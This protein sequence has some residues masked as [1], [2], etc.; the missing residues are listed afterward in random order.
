MSE[1]IVCRIALGFIPGIGSSLTRQLISYCNTAADV[2][3]Q[4]KARLLKI[5]GIGN[6]LADAIVSARSKAMTDAEKEWQL[7]EK[8]KVSL[9]FYTDAAYPDRLKTIADAPALLYYA[10]NANLNEKKVVSIVG[11]RRA[12]EYGKKVTE[13]LVQD[14]KKH[15]CLIVSGLAYGIDIA[16]HRAALRYGLPTIGVMASGVDI[17]YPS[18]HRAT[19]A[20]MRESGGL[21]TENRIGSAPDAPRFPA[22]NRIIAGMADATIVVEAADKGGALITAEL[23]NSYDKD[24]FAVPGNVNQKSSEGCNKLIAKHKASLITSA[25]DIEYFMN[26]TDETQA[27]H[28]GKAKIKPDFTLEYSTEEAIILSLLYDQPEMHID[29]ISWKAQIPINKLSSI[30]LE[31]EFR[32]ILKNL[33][34]KKFIL[35]F[36]M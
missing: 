35:S 7:A 23:A 29:E 12:T 8:L 3:K 5:P 13:E 30:L 36:L 16:A 32:G 31:L 22:R 6:S 25:A 27:K 17:I 20:A 26:W 34:G 4:P 19:A 10:G 15:D 28:K 1:E 33:P 11:T 24:V 21:L 18:E 2:F 14:L 9:L